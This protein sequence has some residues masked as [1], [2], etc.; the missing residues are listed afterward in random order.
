MK[1]FMMFMVKE[2]GRERKKK[3]EE[4]IKMY[5]VNE[6]EKDKMKKGINQ[7]RKEG[8]PNEK[9]RKGQRKRRVEK[10][11]WKEGRKMKESKERRKGGRK[12]NSKGIKSFEE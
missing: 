11:K 8:L 5:T 9:K 3:G 6:D 2:M 1:V 4:V 12:M 10:R 7:G